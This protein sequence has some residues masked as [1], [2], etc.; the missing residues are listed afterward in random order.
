MQDDTVVGNDDLLKD[1]DVGDGVTIDHSNPNVLLR[2]NVTN[3]FFGEYQN[4]DKTFNSLDFSL[5]CRV[6][7]SLKLAEI[8]SYEDGQHETVSGF[9]RVEDIFA[10]I[11]TGDIKVVLEDPETEAV[12]NKSDKNAKGSGPLEKDYLRL[13]VYL[14]FRLLCIGD[15]FDGKQT[16][17]EYPYLSQSALTRIHSGDYDIL[18]KGGI[19]SF[20]D[21]IGK[22]VLNRWNALPKF[23]R[24]Q[25]QEI[26]C[27][28]SNMTD[29]YGKEWLVTIRKLR[30][31][32]VRVKGQYRFFDPSQPINLMFMEVGEYRVPIWPQ[33]ALY[34]YHAGVDIGQ[35]RNGIVAGVNA[36][37]N[38]ENYSS[39]DWSATCGTATQFISP[40]HTVKPELGMVIQVKETKIQIADGKK[41]S[42]KNP[43][44]A[45]IID[46][47]N[48]KSEEDDSVVKTVVDQVENT[49]GINREAI[50]Q[51]E[52]I[53]IDHLE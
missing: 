16:L 1:V 14:T 50:I 37:G 38:L 36:E 30:D 47:S 46:Q 25:A 49:G 19:N 48:N 35:S 9:I 51:K 18:V 22:E 12:N 41:A 21:Y 8:A 39:L 13:A 3:D 32:L 11:K 53:E 44:M 40:E 20:S 31:C 6:M 26:L 45:A 42:I 34:W 29:Q 2:S 5:P 23:F 4:I 33:K 43:S 7:A 10:N 17:V 24:E 28:S 27:N 15:P 52:D